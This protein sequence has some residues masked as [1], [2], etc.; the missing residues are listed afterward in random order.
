MK[1]STKRLTLISKRFNTLLLLVLL[2][3]YLSEA[4]GQLPAD[5]NA[6][7]LHDA[8]NRLAKARPLI[9]RQPDSV[10]LLVLP[11]E[12]VILK[13]GDAS[14]KAEY[15]NVRGLM[16]W[17]A[18]QP[19]QSIIWFKKTLQ[20]PLSE[21]LTNAFA[22]AAN[23][24]GALYRRQGLADS[25]RVYLNLALETDIARNN[26]RGINKTLYD[27]GTMEMNIGHYELAYQ[28]LV[29]ALRSQEKTND[30]SFRL[31]TLT[32][33][34]NL[35]FFLGNNPKA[36]EYYLDALNMARHIGDSSQKVLLLSNLS[37][38]IDDSINL[39]Q[40][41][42]YA[43]EGLIMALKSNDY[44]SLVAFYGN[45]ANAYM[46]QNKT[47]S[48]LIYYEKGLEY[49]TKANNQYLVNNFHLQMAR[50]IQQLGKNNEAYDLYRLGFKSAA[51]IDNLT[52]M[53]DAL[54][55]MAVIDSLRG[56]YRRSLMH[57]TEGT[58]W[59]DSIQK[60]E[61]NNR[62]SELEIK[63]ET[64][65]K[66][67]IIEELE[68]KDHYN[69]LLRLVGILFTT[70]A[71]IVLSLLALLY[72]KQKL[73]GLHR[74]A[75]LKKERIHARE[76]LNNNRKEL[77]AHVLSL[78]KAEEV[79]RNTNTQINHLIPKVDSETSEQLNTL[80]SNLRGS[81]NS[82]KLWREFEQRFDELNNGFINKLLLQ[83]PSLSP[84]E[85]RMC[86][87][88]RLQLSTKDLAELTQRSPRTIEYTRTNIRRKMGLSS[89]DNLL[90]K[91][92][93]IE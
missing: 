84:T 92:W 52:G 54:M 86:A 33:L 42:R 64:E 37:A 39:E 93:S 19:E 14:I 44:N 11:I 32:A 30:S 80:I 26:T 13:E 43:R 58:K 46:K 15:F 74:V 28:N 55:G 82:Q 67:R 65:R 1:F 29:A 40:A 8:T 63:Y 9:F 20:L 75:I 5:S 57:F 78:A 77:T 34:G 7:N 22:E 31:Y 21:A 83:Y 2:A 85:I 76:M 49:S 23:N 48:S 62:I 6:I 45:L 56:D 35:H 12:K 38:I 51:R 47:D 73:I 18:N 69:K 72:R 4:S 17:Q 88:L 3:A 70:A 71:I 81:Q 50:A 87:L 91:L 16:C 79:I 61:S 41:N 89:T 66:E 36:K 53:R 27:L 10:S 25:A 90:T 59:N 60:T 68:S 24:T